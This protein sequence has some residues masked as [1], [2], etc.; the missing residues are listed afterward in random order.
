MPV[1]P[2]PPAIGATENALR[3]LLTRAL[4][5][6]LI[7][8]YDEWVYLNIQE[9]ADDPTL[10]EGL[11]ADAL[12]Q[13]REVVTAARGRLVAAGLLGCDGGLTRIGREQ[14]HRCRTAVAETTQALTAG[15]D[16]AAVRTTLD[17]LD[18]VRGRAEQLLAGCAVPARSR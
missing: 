13:P 6:S 1:R 4:A 5:G 7:G 11:V 9:R 8:G 16:P 18:A 2:L 3:Q 14:L 15:I 17:T 10:V 12:R